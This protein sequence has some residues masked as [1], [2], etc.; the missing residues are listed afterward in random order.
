MR[1]ANSLNN[2]VSDDMIYG[3]KFFVDFY[4]FANIFQTFL[5]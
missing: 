5:H 4:K 1:I 3:G 2:K